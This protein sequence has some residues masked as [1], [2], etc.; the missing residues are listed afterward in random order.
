MSHV[1]TSAVRIEACLCTGSGVGGV[2]RP[3][4]GGQVLPGPAAG[5]GKQGVQATAHGSLRGPLGSG[6]SYKKKW[7]G[8]W[9]GGQSTVMRRCLT[10]EHDPNANCGLAREK[11]KDRVLDVLKFWHY[12][13]ANPN[14]ISNPLFF[15]PP[16]PGKAKYPLSLASLHL[17]RV[18]AYD[19]TLIYEI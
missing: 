7:V 3:L 13:L 4:K 17:Q 1:K 9:T 11:G 18:G 15:C 5:S 8:C 12:E 2:S 19:I 16:P 6:I 14:F 10:Q